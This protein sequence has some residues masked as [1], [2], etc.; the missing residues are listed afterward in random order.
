MTQRG[1]DVG[2]TRSRQTVD[3]LSRGAGRHPIV[4]DQEAATT[5]W[6]QSGVCGAFWLLCERDTA[7]SWALQTCSNSPDSKYLMA[8]STRQAVVVIAFTRR[9]LTAGLRSGDYPEPSAHRSAGPQ[10]RQP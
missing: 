6:E 2:D 1:R 10:S 9:R 3:C 5:G 8:P 4:D 7:R